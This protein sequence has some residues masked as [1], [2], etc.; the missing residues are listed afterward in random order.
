M[1]QK[2]SLGG[3]SLFQAL[4]EELEQGG[5]IFN[6]FKDNG[7]HLTMHFLRFQNQLCLQELIPPC[8]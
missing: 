2:D 6:Y 3:C 1:V 5:F 8:L 7:G 4:F